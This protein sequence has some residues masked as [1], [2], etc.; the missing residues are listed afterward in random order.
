MAKQRPTQLPIP[1]PGAHAFITIADSRQHIHLKHSV[2]DL[3]WPTK[4]GDESFLAGRFED[5]RNVDFY[6]IAP[7]HGMSDRTFEHLCTLLQ[8]TY[9]GNPITS[10]ASLFSEAAKLLSLKYRHATDVTPD[11]A[12]AYI[13]AWARLTKDV[14][15]NQVARLYNES[16]NDQQDALHRFFEQCRNRSLDVLMAIE[17]PQIVLPEGFEREFSSRVM[18][19]ITE[20]YSDE[21]S[22]WIRDDLFY[23]QYHVMAYHLNTTTHFLLST[24]PTLELALVKATAYTLD[25]LGSKLS[26]MMVITRGDT[27]VACADIQ[28]I[29]PA[30]GIL[31]VRKS[32]RKLRWDFDY[33]GERD[34][35]ELP[36]PPVPKEQF[37]SLIYSVEKALGV[38][39]AK[40][41]RLEDELGL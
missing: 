4:D 35:E 9:N 7:I 38:Q 5:V 12:Q 10:K 20:L 16:A 24:A 30:K 1:N 33:K 21:Q 28:Q 18:N 2:D 8:P 11:Q 19:G 29:T 22:A 17:E 23:Q 31:E 3:N 41:G 32:P 6:S 40:V 34:G 15:W 25:A 13:M 37:R 27:Y 14:P 39:W 36:D 26:D